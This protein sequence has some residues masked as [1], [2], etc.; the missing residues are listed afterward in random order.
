M[1]CR[2]E[3]LQGFAASEAFFA[4]LE[5][6]LTV[7]RPPAAKR[8]VPCDSSREA[9]EECSPRRQAVGTTQ[10][11]NTQP[12]GGERKRPSGAFPATAAAKRRKNAAHGASR[13]YHTR[14]KHPAPRGRKK[15]AR[16]NVPCDSSR[17][18]AQECSPRRQ[19]VGTTQ[20]RNT[21]PRGAKE[22]GQAE[23]S[24]QQQPRSGARM[25]PTA[26]AVGTTQG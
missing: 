15:A 16:R 13:G 21:Q 5:I 17:E 12:R 24:V 2:S 19:A 9:A 10:G 22:S 4:I 20:G 7:P 1:P 25:Q 18:A 8:S 11:R 26:P 6:A 23:R 14:M 3:A